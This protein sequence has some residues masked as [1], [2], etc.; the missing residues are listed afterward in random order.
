M[1]GSATNSP[2]S[3]PTFI[4]SMKPPVGARIC[5]LPSPMRR[6]IGSMMKSWSS[7]TKKNAIPQPM[8]SAQTETI[9]RFRSSSRCSRNDILPPAPSSS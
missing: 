4:I 6:A 2:P 8:T 3:A 1:T 9:S 5:I 7:P